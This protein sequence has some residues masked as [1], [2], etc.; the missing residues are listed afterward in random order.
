M[1]LEEINSQRVRSEWIFSATIMNLRG[2][3]H[4]AVAGQEYMMLL[5]DSVH[6]AWLPHGAVNQVY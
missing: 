1:E 5:S 6:R 3:V 4:I 2:H